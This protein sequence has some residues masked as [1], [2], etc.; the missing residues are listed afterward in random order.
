MD[1]ANILIL[2]EDYVFRAARLWPDKRLVEVQVSAAAALGMC[3][4]TVPA[5]GC[6]AA[7][8]QR[9]RANPASAQDLAVVWKL[10]EPILPQLQV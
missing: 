6:A 5:A 10:V 2:E 3:N 1:A 9:R 7:A 8:E 4:K